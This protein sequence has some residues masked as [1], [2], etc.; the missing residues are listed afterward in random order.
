MNLKLKSKKIIGGSGYVKL[1][2]D[3]INPCYKDKIRHG[4]HG[5]KQKKKYKNQKGGNEILTCQNST[6]TPHSLGNK[7][8]TA[9]DT[10]G[11]V[12]FRHMQVPVNGTQLLTLGENYVQ[13]NKCSASGPFNL[14]TRPIPTTNLPKKIIGGRKN[15]KKVPKKRAIKKVTK[16]KL[17]KKV[18][19]KK[20]V[21]K[22]TKKKVVKK[23]T[24]KKVVKKVTKKVV[25]K[26][27]KKVVKKM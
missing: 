15:V 18:T 8:G 7:P 21:K 16:K 9:I 2:E 6:T 14:E 3:E 1:F 11:P 13:N 19:K 10:S 25:K 5:G 26:V 4:W 20:V 27:T 17:T 24:K 12:F 22:V 23:V